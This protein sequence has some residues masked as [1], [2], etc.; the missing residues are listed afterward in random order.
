MDILDGINAFL[1]GKVLLIP[2]LGAG[3]LFTVKLGAPQLRLPS[4]LMRAESPRNKGV[5]QFR[6]VCMSLGA[7][8]GT[9]N[10]TGVTAAVAAG[11]AGAVF[12]MWVSAFLG[13]AT[14]YAENCLSV[15]Y[16]DEKCRG[17]MA[18][19]EKGLGCRRLAC[20][21]AVMC[22]I[23]SFGMGGMIQVS[24]FAVSLGECVHVP[25]YAA[26]AAVFVMIYAVVSGGARRIGSAAQALLPAVS[27]VYGVLCIAVL[28][29]FREDI[30]AAI[31]AVFAQAFGVK[32]AVGGVCGYRIS[33]AVT[34]GISRG[35]FSN[36]AGLGS[37]PLLHSAAE[38]DSTHTQGMWGMFEVFLDTV[39]CCTL[40]AFTLLVSGQDT[41]QK[42]ASAVTGR[43]SPYI[44]AVL[45][46]VFA[47]C[48]VM[49]WY[50]CGESAFLYLSGDERTSI[51]PLLFAA[52]ASLG[53]VVPVGA[54]WALSDIFNGFMAFPNLIGLFF[55]RNKINRNEN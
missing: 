48:T 36:E 4:F 54:V 28:I 50:Y 24:S 49:G 30:S 45:L 34:A 31:G 52:F 5:S 13:M 3:A 8:M 41:V 21:F 17:P 42:A 6:T 27:V 9:G 47:F 26:A 25:Q 33:R 12:W 18:Y 7:S 38:S 55:L 37:S 15:R 19:L 11:G 53:A 29:K 20:V 2:L 39:V 22:V 46:A 23:A 10:I 16:S 35:V 32:Q 14:V 1:W 43:S 51:F 40:T 44:I